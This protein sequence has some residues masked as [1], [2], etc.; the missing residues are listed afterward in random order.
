ML[1]LFQEKY[2]REREREIEEIANFSCLVG[3]EIEKR[4]KRL[5]GTTPF[6]E[7]SSAKKG[8]REACYFLIPFIPLLHKTF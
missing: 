4:D 8:K 6:T 3:R 7:Y 2:N 5:M 1:R